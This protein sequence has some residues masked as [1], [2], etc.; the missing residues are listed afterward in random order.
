MRF[1]YRCPTCKRF[2]KLN[3]QCTKCTGLSEHELL[4]QNVRL[5]KE[6]QALQ[7]RQRVERKSFREYARVE[8][9]V[10]G[11]VKELSRLL[12]HDSFTLEQKPLQ[13]GREQTV[14]LVQ[15]SDLHFNELVDLPS[16]NYNFYVAAQRLQKLAHKV[17]QQ[18]ALHK[19]KGIVVTFLGD[20][21]NSDRRLDELLSNATNRTKA[22]L[23]AVDILQAFLRDIAT[24]APVEVYGITGNESR[25][26]K[27]CGWSEP[28]ATDSYDLMIY[29]ILKK[30]LSSH[31]SLAFK[32]FKANEL[33]LSVL[34]R[35]F[36]CIHGHQVKQNVQK[37][38][39]EIIGKYVPQGIAV[40]YVLFGHIHASYIGDYHS[41]NA[42]LVGS[43]AYSEAGLNF[44]SKAAQNL[45]V[46]TKTS[47]DSIK[48]DL[49][50]SSAYPGYAFNQSWDSAYNA[51]SAGKLKAQTVV[52]QVTI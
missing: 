14:I 9:A 11:Y 43:N 24:A 18:V 17:K 16:N 12:Q 33:V 48:V 4:V 32:G 39:Q 29:E 36:L 37:A 5:S 40:E 38:V 34:N 7:D 41:R 49:Q 30:W 19:A 42:S 20:L 50:D 46:V 8:N 27:E 28:L 51:K 23:V 26:N 22:T 2:T 1:S 10:S 31:P 35:T 44:C 47:I 15:L 45:H 3:A 13:K 52:F 25:V 6:K 21:L